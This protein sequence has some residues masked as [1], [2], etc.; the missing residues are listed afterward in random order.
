LIGFRPGVVFLGQAQPHLRHQQQGG[1]SNKE[2]RDFASW[3][4]FAMSKHSLA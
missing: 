3:T 4:V 2:A 1:A